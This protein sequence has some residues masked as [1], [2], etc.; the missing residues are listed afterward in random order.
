MAEALDFLLDDTNDLVIKDGDFALCESEMQEVAIILN[1]NQGDLK[2][3][4]MLGPNLLQLKKTNVSRFD[5]EKRLR[6]HL[7]QD[8]KVYEDLKNKIK[9]IINA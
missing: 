6:V 8:G 1:L 4:P 7:A 3:H 2:P 5:M 9:S